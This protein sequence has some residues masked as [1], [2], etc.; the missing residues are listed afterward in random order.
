MDFADFAAAADPPLD[1]LCLALAAAFGTV[2]RD[3]ALAHLD[4]LSEEVR[5]DGDLIAILAGRHGF[6]GDQRTYEAPRNSMLDQVL[7]RRRGLPITL[8]VVDVEV[9]RRAG[10]AFAGVG[11][12]GHFV[13]AGPD[14]GLVDPFRSGAAV[15]FD[16]PREIVRPWGAHEIALRILN[17]LVAAYGRRGDLGRAVRAAEMRLLLPGGDAYKG[18]A[19][20]LRA[21]LN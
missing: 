19:R 7:E 14:G 13:V 17:N 18:E 2:D 20:A 4:A 15:T 3:G 9:G 10:L 1:E 11:L 6:A 5:T 21:R 16:G 12:P 8:S